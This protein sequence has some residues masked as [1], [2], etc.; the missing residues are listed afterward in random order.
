MKVCLKPQHNALFEVRARYQWADTIPEPMQAEYGEYA[1][2][3]EI[4]A[5]QKVGTPA[6]RGMRRDDR[7]IYHAEFLL[8]FAALLGELSS[9]I[10][11]QYNSGLYASARLEIVPLGYQQ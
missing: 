2:A 10:A 11:A 7:G 1:G 5:L 4:S 6:L 8:D 3:A 9:I